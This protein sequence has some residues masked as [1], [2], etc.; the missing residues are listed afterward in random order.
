MANSSYIHD[1]VFN[2]YNGVHIGN[3][4]VIEED[5]KQWPNHIRSEKDLETMMLYLKGSAGRVKLRKH[6]D[7]LYVFDLRTS[8]SESPLSEKLIYSPT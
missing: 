6:Q 4:I 2:K 7:Y 3:A 8:A 5:G 1:Y